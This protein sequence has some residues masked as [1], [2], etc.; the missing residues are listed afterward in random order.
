MVTQ[1]VICKCLLG[2]GFATKISEQR[3]ERGKGECWGKV[4]GISKENA[5]NEEGKYEGNV[6]V[7]VKVKVG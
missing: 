2:K 1:R 7:E 3:R 5:Q 6:K 4:R